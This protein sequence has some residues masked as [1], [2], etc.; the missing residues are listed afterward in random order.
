MLS[1]TKK[2]NINRRPAKIIDQ[3][4]EQMDNDIQLFFVVYSTN[5]NNQKVFPINSFI[6]FGKPCNWINARM[7]IY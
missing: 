1:S 5:T 7:N 6:T 3:Q 2:E 4:T